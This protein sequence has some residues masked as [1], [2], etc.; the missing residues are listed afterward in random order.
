MKKEIWI[1]ASI[2]GWALFIAFVSW[3]YGWKVYEAKIRNAYLQGVADV[4]EQ[5]IYLR[6]VNDAVSQVIRQAQQGKVIINTNNGR[7][8][9]VPI[10]PTP[11]LGGADPNGGK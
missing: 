8:V 4:N 5:E 9:L 10:N 11:P 1:A 2:V 3:N 7:L 6:G